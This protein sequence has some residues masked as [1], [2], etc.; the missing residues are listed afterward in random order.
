MRE[1]K[2]PKISLYVKSEELRHNIELLA[3]YD[4]ASI[5][6]IVS[7]ALQEYVNSRSGDIDFMHRQEQER[8]DRRSNNDG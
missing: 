4:E 3:Q 1:K 5:T 2:T 8:R 6:D 7:K